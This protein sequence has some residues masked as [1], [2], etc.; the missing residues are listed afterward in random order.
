MKAMERISERK[1]IPMIMPPWVEKTADRAEILVSFPFQ[2]ALK[3]VCPSLIIMAPSTIVVNMI[4]TN[5]TR[6]TIS[7]HERSSSGTG[8]CRIYWLLLAKC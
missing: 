8:F 7:V 4:S 6:Q 1:N 2:V 3:K 5:I